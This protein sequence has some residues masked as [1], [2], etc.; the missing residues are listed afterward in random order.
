MTTENLVR[1]ETVATSLGVSQATI[2]KWIRTG[3]I[4]KHAYIKVGAVYRFK[5]SKIEE[6]LYGTND[7][8]AVEAE[9]EPEHE[10]PENDQD[11]EDD[12]EDDSQLGFD[13]DHPDNTDEDL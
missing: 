2:R 7:L 6:A 11:Q 10:E 1:I 13:F 8:P 3:A 5:L 12:D 9:S 4:P